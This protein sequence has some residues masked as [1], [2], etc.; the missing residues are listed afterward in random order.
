MKKYFFLAVI[1][2]FGGS[3]L[4]QNIQGVINIYTPVTAISQLNVTV[5][6]TNGFAVGDKVLV[7]K[8]KGA[9]INQTNTA[10]YG[11]TI[12]M[13]GAG[14]YQFSTI[15]SINGNQLT[16][17]PFCNIYDGTAYIQM[18]RVPIYP[19][20]AVVGNLTCTPWNGTIG[21]VLV[22]E[23]PGTLTLNDSIDV[24]GRGFRGGQFLG[25]NFNCA[26]TMFVTS[27]AANSD[28]EKG[29]GV[30]D[31]IAGQ[32]CGGGKLANG[33]G[34]SYAGNAGGGG[35]GNAGVGGQGGNQFSG[36]NPINKNG[37]G[38]LAL[39]R[40]NNQLY[41]GGG[42]GGPERDN[43]QTIYPG[44]A[45]GGLIYITANNIVGNGNSIISNGDTVQT[46]GDEGGSGGG[47]GGSIYL[48]SP[49]F[50]GN[51]T[52]RADGGHGS[53]NFNTLFSAQC[54]GPGG[55]GGGGLVA[56]PQATTPAGVTVSRVG[57][58]AGI[59]LNPAS[60]CYNTTYGAV[61]GSAGSTLHN[62]VCYTSNPIAV[63]LGPDQ[64]LC[65]G[66]TLTLD[67]GAGY[68]SYLWDDN[69]TNQTRQITN[70][71]TYY[72]FVVGNDGCTGSD[73]INVFIDTTLTAGFTYTFDY[74]CSS[75][76]VYFTNTSV[77][78]VNY[79]WFFGDGSTSSVTNPMHIYGA[80][81]AYNVRLVAGNMPC[82]DTIDI[83]IFISHTVDAVISLSQDSL[84]FGDQIIAD[85]F[86][87]QPALGQGVR[88]TLW[89]F[90]D[91][92]TSTSSV[93]AHTYAQPGIFTVTLYVTDSIGCIDSA[94]RQVFV[95]PT[96]FASMHLS[97]DMLCIGEP[98][99]FTDSIGAGAKSF[100]W[101]FDDGN[102]LI[103]IH[104]PQYSFANPGTYNVTLTALY[105]ICLPYVQDTIITVSDYPLIDLGEELKYCPGIDTAVLIFNKINPAQILEWSTGMSADKILAKETG[106][107][108]ARATDNGC[109]TT[110]SVWVMRDCY[111]NIP[112]SFS[113]NGD[114]MND[115]F[116]PR[117]L[118]SSGV[119]EFKMKIMNRWGELIF[120][121]SAIDGRGWDGTFGGKDQS[122]G[123]YVYMI[124]A[125]WRNGFRN[126]FTG[127]LTL[128]R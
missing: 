23:T 5:G 56:F 109:T 87:S 42:G 45:G 100:T 7:I 41:L 121:T 58:A 30:A 93:V 36:C 34:G 10:N 122:V 22:F 8:M 126:S 69:S 31:Y 48:V 79:V 103:N 43:S 91:G 82:F 11:D 92:T 113:P 1:C 80:Q 89:D 114:G 102:I 99:F 39:A 61:A 78:A 62:F 55:G 12:A 53:N 24:S 96:P 94:K 101:D 44:G 60:S 29:E 115:Y 21:G 20:P 112:N 110:D 14:R 75:D 32:E 95:E 9:T 117:Q 127:N 77:G 47:A 54:H 2:V 27:L 63:N 25:G 70:P 37:I 97:D 66:Q 116:I 19:N 84:C 76:T 104:N 4:A 118:L 71:G 16:L 50:T 13:N 123:V 106:R 74:G 111:L 35:G 128:M 65:I 6:S 17:F 98:A 88:T 105:E 38:G 40:T 73:T 49:S 26:S 85:D 108:W 120:E 67:A 72:V 15:T 124:E 125:K 33:G 107:Y 57:G 64:P 52:V 3:A 51:L 46:F 18:I 119:Q 68:A 59:V 81:G 83:P 86:G 28:G 90:G